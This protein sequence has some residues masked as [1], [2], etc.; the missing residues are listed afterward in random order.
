VQVRILSPAPLERLIMARKKQ[1]EK[2][3]LVP[4]LTVLIKDGMIE[5]I[6]KICRAADISLGA[7]T[8]AALEHV[9]K[10]CNEGRLHITKPLTEE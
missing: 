2:W 8:T 6:T 4:A 9:I 1:E 3:K 7:F 10:E 5:D